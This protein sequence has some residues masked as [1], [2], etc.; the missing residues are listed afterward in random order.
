MKAKE[1]VKPNQNNAKKLPGFL[2]SSLTS[3]VSKCIPGI[4]DV[5]DNV[6]REP[7]PHSTDNRKE[8]AEGKL[9]SKNLTS[10]S[11]LTS[12]FSKTIPGET[13]DVPSYSNSHF[14]DKG[15]TED[16]RQEENEKTPPSS[17]ASSSNSP[18]VSKTIPGITSR[19]ARPYQTTFH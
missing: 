17:S 2:D 10:D 11:S 18:Q 14:I 16:E 9:K 6:S 4:H 13:R 19:C 15:K 1:T 7:N 3:Q 12:Q 5:A 8:A